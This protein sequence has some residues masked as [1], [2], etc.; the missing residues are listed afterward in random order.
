MNAQSRSLRYLI[1][2]SWLMAGLVVVFGIA[3]ILD[4]S[5]IDGSPA[6]LKPAKFAASLSL[7]GFTFAWILGQLPSWPRLVQWSAWATTLAALV[8]LSLIALQ[9]SRGVASHF[10]ID[11]PFDKTVFAVMGGV[12]TVQTVSA[13]FV[14][15]ALW[16]QPVP[17]RAMGWAVRLGVTITVLGASVG[18]VMTPP[19]ARQL[20]LWHSTGR[21]PRQGAHSIG[22]EDGGPGL[23]GFHWSTK[24]GD[25]RVA[26]F[27]GLHAMQAIPMVAFATRNWKSRRSRVALVQGAALSYATLFAL[28][29]AQALAGQPVTAPSG[30]IAVALGIWALFTA[31]LVASTVYALRQAPSDYSTPLPDAP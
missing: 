17:D 7:Y 5:T 6:W 11:T 13:G 30:W 1:R 2:T 27:I 18:G 9:A 28:L 22:G 10:N 15:V 19:T 25:I 12:I 21:Y 20:S 14:G 23:P 8:E 26:H 29:L 31:A 3:L 4:H 16:R 24:H